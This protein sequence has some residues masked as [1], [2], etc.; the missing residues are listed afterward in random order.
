MIKSLHDISLTDSILHLI[1]INKVLLLHDLKR[2]DLTIILLAALEHSAERSLSD[3]LNDI[4]VFKLYVLRVCHL[5]SWLGR[6]EVVRPL[7]GRAALARS[8]GTLL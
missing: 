6:H 3:G 4:K 1:I 8:E 2:K 7:G 5:F